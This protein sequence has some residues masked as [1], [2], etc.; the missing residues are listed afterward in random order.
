MAAVTAI[1]KHLIDTIR[2]DCSTMI[3]FFKDSNKREFRINRGAE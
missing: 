3:Q 2:E 1:G